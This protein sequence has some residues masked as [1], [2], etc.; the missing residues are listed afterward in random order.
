MGGSVSASAFVLPGTSRSS[1]SGPVPESL[2]LAAAAKKARK[3]YFECLMTNYLCFMSFFRRHRLRM[4]YSVGETGRRSVERQL[5]CAT[6][7]SSTREVSPRLLG[8]RA[9]RQGHRTERDEPSL[10]HGQGRIFDGAD[11]LAGQR[12]VC[13]STQGSNPE[14]SVG[15]RISARHEEVTKKKMKPVTLV[16]ATVYDVVVD[17]VTSRRSVRL[18]PSVRSMSTRH[19]A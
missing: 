17:L 7:L 9:G 19:S 14:V 6:A 16:R 18:W 10:F 11:F 1:V 15:V 4:Q 8:G 3:E 2:V 12:H 13:G 5:S